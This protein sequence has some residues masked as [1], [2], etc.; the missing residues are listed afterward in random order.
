MGLRRG[1]LV[2]HALAFVE[3]RHHWQ[4]WRLLADSHAFHQALG[5]AVS[6]IGREVANQRNHGV[7]A[8]IVLPVKG[9]KVVPTDAV[10]RFFGAA[11]RRCIRVIAIYRLHEFLFGDGPGIGFLLH[12]RQL[13][14]GLFTRQVGRG[15]RGRG[16]QPGEHLQRRIQQFRVAQAAQFQQPHVA[17]TG[18]THLG[19]E[20][21]EMLGYLVGVH[22]LHAFH[23]HVVGHA[24]QSGLFRLVARRT[25][26]ESHLRLHNGQ[27]VS[28]DKQHS[29]AVGCG[30]GLD[31]RHGHGLPGPQQRCRGDTFYANAHGSCLPCYAF[32][33]RLS[34]RWVSCPDRPP[35]GCHPPDIC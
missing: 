16:I 14:A 10:E 32:C 31:S 12:H 22:A 26:V 29:G 8:H 6:S 21:V 5:H 18:G 34:G 30:P 33:R 28:F 7:P 19:T 24:R 23:Q 17:Q 1:K 13:G 20:A 25:G 35:R 4:L 15:K 3:I 27:L 9:D 11:G 2:T